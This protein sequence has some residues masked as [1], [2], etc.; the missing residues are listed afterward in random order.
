MGKDYYA[1]LGV[2]RDASASQIKKAYHMLALKYHPDKNPDSREEAEKKFKEVSEAYDV[3]G[4]E[5]KKQAYDR[6]GEAGLRG[7]G[8]MGGE[9][10][11]G[12]GMPGGMGGGFSAEDASR[13]F[14]QFFGSSDPFSGG[15]MN[16][17]S[18]EGG[19]GLHS[20]FSSFGGM[21]GEG[22]MGGMGGFPGMGGMGGFPGMGGMGQQQQQ[23]AR[24]S[25]PPPVEFT[26][27]C[28]LEELLTGTKK[29]FS[30]TRKLRNGGENKKTFE[31]DV[32]PGYKAGTR[33][34]FENDGGYIGGYG[35]DADLIFILEEKPHPQFHRDGA[36]LK[37]TAT[38]PL[39]DALLGTS[40]K[41]PK[42]GGGTVDISLPGVTTSGRKLRVSGEGLPDRKKNGQRGDLY[43]E[44]KVAMP[45]KLTDEQKEL[46]KKAFPA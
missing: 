24:G 13:V 33:V 19:P 38:I 18:A 15:G 7:D 27:A 29:K 4:D 36:D 16:F 12:G 8:G 5:K 9:G 39:R 26:Y 3:L 44:V 11:M 25:K 31:V 1:I 10:G 30:V 6:F 41:V 14:Q 20:F 21:G 17:S 22:G 23:Q 2:P 40:I 34:T 46:V 37:H 32:K 28:S 43:V 45:S 35:S 42:L